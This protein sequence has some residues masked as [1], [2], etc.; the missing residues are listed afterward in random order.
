MSDSSQ[1]N[2]EENQPE[3]QPSILEL[4]YGKEVLKRGYTCGPNLLYDYEEYLYL[5]STQGQIIK[6]ILRYWKGRYPC[7]AIATLAKHLRKGERCIQVNIRKMAT[8]L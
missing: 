2:S 7:P 5:T 1:V 4:R 6:F 3:E 8:K